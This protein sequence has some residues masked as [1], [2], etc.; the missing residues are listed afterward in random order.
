VGQQ[1]AET[2]SVLPPLQMLDDPS[3]ADRPRPPRATCEFYRPDGAF[4]STF[5][6][7]LCFVDGRLAAKDVARTGPAL[8]EEET[9]G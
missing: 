9:A 3:D 7:R 1:R 6:Y 2:A 5:A 8:V 4:S